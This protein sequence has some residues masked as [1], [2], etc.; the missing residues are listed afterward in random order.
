M[1]GLEEFDRVKDLPGEELVRRYLHLND[2]LLL[3][4]LRPDRRAAAEYALRLLR[5]EGDPMRQRVWDDLSTEERQLV[6]RAFASYARW[7]DESK[8]RIR[9]TE[10]TPFHRYR[11]L[12]YLTR[13]LCLDVQSE[14]EGL[15]FIMD[16]LWLW[17]MHLAGEIM[18]LNAVVEQYAGEGIFNTQMEKDEAIERAKHELPQLTYEGERSLSEEKTQLLSSLEVALSPDQDYAL[19]EV[20]QAVARGSGLHIV[21]DCFWQ[22]RRPLINTET[23]LTALETSCHPRDERLEGRDKQLYRLPAW[24]WGDA[25]PFLRFRSVDRAR[26]LASLWPESVVEEVDRWL[27]PRLREAMESTGGRIHFRVQFPSDLRR[28]MAVATALDDVQLEFGANMMYEDP[29][30]EEGAWRQ[31]IREAFVGRLTG[32]NLAYFRLFTSLTDEQWQQASDP[33]SGLDCGELTHEQ[34]ARLQSGQARHNILHTAEMIR[35]QRIHAHGVLPGPGREGRLRAEED[36][37]QAVLEVRVDAP[38][39]LSYSSELAF[40]AEY[41]GSD[42][43]SIKRSVSAA[44]PVRSEFVK[45]I[46]ASVGVEGR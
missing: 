38:K 2:Q 4:L 45:E 3:T 10:P 42:Y 7:P 39:G 15:H 17:P 30:L 16:V 35:T 13:G 37:S 33:E 14:E 12:R 6:R 27:E 22:A 32:L 46:E 41:S 11:G 26:W 28:L 23:A 9:L 29:S 31:T 34:I 43:W 24:E 1:E 40:L 44:N 18:E 20:Q 19:W 21:S 36:D 5:S 8:M 25:G